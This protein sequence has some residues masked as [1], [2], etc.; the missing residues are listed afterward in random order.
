MP[1]M[2]QQEIIWSYSTHAKG[3]MGD[4]PCGETSDDNASPPPPHIF[5]QTTLE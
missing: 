1:M 3:T 5:V 2:E 4:I